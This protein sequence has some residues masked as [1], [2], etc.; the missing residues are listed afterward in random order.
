MQNDHQLPGVAVRVQEHA[1]DGDAAAA[2]VEP[3]QAERAQLVRGPR[4]PVA[5][6]A[7]RVADQRRVRS[8]RRPHV[9]EPDGG[10]LDQ[11]VGQCPNQLNTLIAFNERSSPSSGVG[12]RPTPGSVVG[13]FFNNSVLVVGLDQ[14]V[15]LWSF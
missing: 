12:I 2:H 11:L 3:L 9:R 14:V 15:G 10:R 6:E 4:L 8:R 5:L 1:A 7:V 13:F